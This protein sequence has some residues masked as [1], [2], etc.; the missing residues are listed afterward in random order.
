MA[1][2][3]KPHFGYSR[4]RNAIICHAHNFRKFKFHCSLTHDLGHDFEQAE[5]A[6][7]MWASLYLLCRRSV[8][9]ALGGRSKFYIAEIRIFDLVTPVTLTLTRWPLYM[10][11]TRIPWRYTGCVK[12]TSSL[13]KV[14]V[15]QPANAC[16]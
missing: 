13:S 10:N 8:P 12:Y 7:K 11:L 14:I 5:T 9:I 15:L 16:T 1:A 3:V 4:A 6:W 2:T